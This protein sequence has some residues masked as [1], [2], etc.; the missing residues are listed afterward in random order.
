MEKGTRICVAKG[1]KA[2]GMTGT[3]FWEGENQWGEAEHQE[4][5]QDQTAE[6]HAGGTLARRFIR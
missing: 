5:E 4:E 1:R 2:R 3:V 6:F